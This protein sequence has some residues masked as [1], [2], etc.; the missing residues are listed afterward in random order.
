M[1]SVFYI[2]NVFYRCYSNKF[3]FEFEFEL[4]TCIQYSR[5]LRKTTDGTVCIHNLSYHYVMYEMMGIIAVLQI[6]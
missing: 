6:V 3:E 1:F 2:K 4:H 5:I